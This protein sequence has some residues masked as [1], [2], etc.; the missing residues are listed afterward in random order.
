MPRNVDILNQE[1][2]SSRKIV[3]TG[4]KVLGGSG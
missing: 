1:E 3:S 4:I 2:Q